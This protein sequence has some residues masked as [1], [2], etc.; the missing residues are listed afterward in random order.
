[1]MNMADRYASRV[2]ARAWRM[3]SLPPPPASG[4]QHRLP[5][6]KGRVY[7]NR[8]IQISQ[9]LT[10]HQDK[11]KAWSQK[12]LHGRH[13]YDLQQQHVD[14][15]ASNAWLKR[16]D[17]F[18]ETEGFMLT[19]QDQ[20]ID[21]KN[22]QKFIIRRPNISDT[23]RHCHSS[24]ETIQHIT[25]AC[26]SIAQTDYKHRHDQ[27]PAIIHQNLAFQ[28]KLISE[29]VPCYKYQPQSV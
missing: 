19:I 2:G 7:I 23:C 17:L 20:V 25:G 8:N 10:D 5:L 11:I 3:T 26:K 24:P 12:S 1:M 4:G 29:K 9:N 15:V 6:W 27:V 21:T 14:M 28:Y 16:G 18:P 22:Y 13:R